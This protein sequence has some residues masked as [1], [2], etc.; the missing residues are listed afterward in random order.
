M[1]TYKVYELDPAEALNQD[2]FLILGFRDGK[3]FRSRLVKVPREEWKTS[4]KY[5]TPSSNP[6]V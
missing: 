5:L 2:R 6:N 4:E 3:P 1:I